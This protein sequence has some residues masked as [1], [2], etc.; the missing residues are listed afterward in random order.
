MFEFFTL[1]FFI[2]A[3]ETAPAQLTPL[4]ALKVQAKVQVIKGGFPHLGHAKVVDHD[5]SLVVRNF[6]HGPNVILLTEHCPA[7]LSVNEEG[8]DGFLLIWFKLHEGVGN[9]VCIHFLRC[10]WEPKD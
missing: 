10:P 2:Q 1:H 9:G 4:E 3:Q 6:I 7:A 8:H 5:P